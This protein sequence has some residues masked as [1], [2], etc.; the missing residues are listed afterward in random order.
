MSRYLVDKFLY[1]VDRSEAWEAA[2]REGPAAFV[3][4]WEEN[5]AGKLFEGEYT[6]AHRFTEEERTALVG[7]DFERLYALGAHPFIL[8]TLMLPIY[9]KDEPNFFEFVQKYNAKIRPYGRPDF[10]T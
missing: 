5:E 4:D 9:Q 7:K 1:Q 8:W 6:T 10:A 3:Q 2:Y